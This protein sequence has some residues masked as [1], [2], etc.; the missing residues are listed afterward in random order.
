MER[1]VVRLAGCAHEFSPTRTL[2][3]ALGW[4]SALK[5]DVAL[6]A[7][8]YQP[9]AP[10]PHAPQ[11]RAADDAADRLV[12][13]CGGRDEGSAARVCVLAQAHVAVLALAPVPGWS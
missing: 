4:D 6:V 3:S 5:A 7:G 12:S 9:H 10:Q 8:A 11:S 13:R 1:E 2:L